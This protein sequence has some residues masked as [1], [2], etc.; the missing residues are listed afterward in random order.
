VLDIES[1]VFSETD[2]GLLTLV[3]HP[4]FPRTPY[5]YVTVCV[6]VCVCACVYVCVCACVC[7]CMYVCVCVCVRAPTRVSR[8]HQNTHKNTRS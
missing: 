3:F 5:A 4:D 7:A 8:L 2:R 1:L 6:C